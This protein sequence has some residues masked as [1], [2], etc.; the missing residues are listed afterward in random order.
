[1][2]DNKTR[3]SNRMAKLIGTPI[4][5][6]HIAAIAKLENQFY[7]EMSAAKNDY[8][9]YKKLESINAELLEALQVAEDM[10]NVLE[11]TEDVSQERIRQASDYVTEA[12]RKA[13]R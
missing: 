10:L 12:I 7:A 9:R 1:M 5:L 6:E 3:I 13:S 8:E 2:T 4:T 11:N